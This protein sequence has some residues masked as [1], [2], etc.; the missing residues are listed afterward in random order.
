M[1]HAGSLGST[2]EAQEF[3]K[4]QPNFRIFS[5]NILAVLEK[6]ELKHFGMDAR[7]TKLRYGILAIILGN[8]VW[9]PART[10]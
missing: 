8:R 10:R 9:N 2:K 5:S 4:A 7:L 1:K 6:K 3:L